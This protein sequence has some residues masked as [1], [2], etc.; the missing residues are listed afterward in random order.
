LSKTKSLYL[1]KPKLCSETL[2][3]SQFCQSVLNQVLAVLIEV[4]F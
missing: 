4:W 3:V 1:L 2:V